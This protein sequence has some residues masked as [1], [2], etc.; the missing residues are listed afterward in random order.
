[1]LAALVV[2]GLGKGKQPRPDLV[3][4][5]LTQDDEETT[6]SISST[7]EK[8]GMPVR[9]EVHHG[10]G[11]GGQTNHGGPVQGS[12]RC[13]D[14]LRT[15]QRP[16]RYTISPAPDN[17]D[18]NVGHHY[19]PFKILTLSGHGVA[20]TKWVQIRVGI[21]PTVEGCMQKGSLVYLGDVHAAPDFD[22]GNVPEYPHEQRCHF[23]SDYARRHEVD[24]ALERIGDKS[25]IAEVVRFHRTMDAIERLQK[26]IQEWEDQLYCIGNN[27]HKCVRRLERAHT[28][29]W[30]F[31]EE[32]IT[33]GLQLITPWVVEHGHQEKEH[34]DRERGHSG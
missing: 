2:E 23:L 1:M 20:N 30:V 6:I 22:H 14:P 34:Q 25:L 13:Y 8:E 31:E 21:N 15:M 28:L 27:N 3:V 7:E 16:M 26:E 10:G 11:V 9:V 12:S 24:D 29:A 17:F 4:H 33:N 19:V 5:D 32:E 18:R